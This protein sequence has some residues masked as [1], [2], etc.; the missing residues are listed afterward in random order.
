MPTRVPNPQPPSLPFPQPS[1]AGP[2]LEGR[3]RRRADSAPWQCQTGAAA[4]CPAGCAGDRATGCLKQRWSSGWTQ[5]AGAACSSGT[6]RRHACGTASTGVGTV[7]PRPAPKQLAPQHKKPSA[8]LAGHHQRPCN[9]SAAHVQPLTR[10]HA[11]ASAHG[12]AG[13]GELGREGAGAARRRARAHA[14]RPSRQQAGCQRATPGSASQTQRTRAAAILCLTARRLPPAATRAGAANR[15]PAR[16]PQWRGAPPTA[17]PPPRPGCPRARSAGT[18]GGVGVGNFVV[19]REGRG[20]NHWACGGATAGLPKNEVL[21]AEPW[22]RCCGQPLTLSYR[23]DCSIIRNAPQEEQAVF[24]LH[25][26]Q[27]CRE[28]AAQ[29][30]AGLSNAASPPPRLPARSNLPCRRCHSSGSTG[31]RARG[32]IGC[33]HQ[34]QGLEA[35]SPSWTTSS[36]RCAIRAGASHTLSV[37]PQR[38]T[39]WPGTFGACGAGKEGQCQASVAA[40]T[41]ELTH[42]GGPTD[43]SGVARRAP[44]GRVQAAAQAGAGAS[45]PARGRPLTCTVRMRLSLSRGPP[46]KN[47]T[48]ERTMKGGAKQDGARAGCWGERDVARWGVPA[49]RTPAG[50]AWDPPPS[51]RQRPLPL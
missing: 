25:V 38:R 8:H 47:N 32:R 35:S 9:H 14:N 13:Q 37:E 28:G 40:G 44:R 19:G 6:V 10:G 30:V 41:Y 27:H 45:S 33:A 51:P 48:W 43:P 3:R 39:V 17:A 15:A 16:K 46:S 12:P 2:P 50:T 49:R 29:G 11:P 22:A 21:P 24:Q 36:G 4:A 26:L 42:A 1:P 23:Q 34:R 18:R 31:R 20:T 7:L 5:A